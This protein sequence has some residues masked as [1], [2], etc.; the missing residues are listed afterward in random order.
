MEPVPCR[1]LEDG[2]IRHGTGFIRSQLVRA[3]IQMLMMLSEEEG[4][5]LWQCC[6]AEWDMG[7]G[8]WGFTLSLCRSWAG[9]LLCAEGMYWGTSVLG[10]QG[11]VGWWVPKWI[12]L[13]PGAPG[14][15]SL[16]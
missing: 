14:E 7:E 10:L 3:L 16:C 11:L 15:Y 4:A 2:I 1:G 8:L 9:K 13:L 6:V 12:V 5:E